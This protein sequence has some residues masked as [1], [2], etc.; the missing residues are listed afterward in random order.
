MKNIIF[1]LV[2]VFLVTSISTASDVAILTPE[3]TNIDVTK[4]EFATLIKAAKTGDIPTLNKALNADVNVNETTNTGATALMIA[5]KWGN[6][7]VIKVLLKEGADV[8]V[9]NKSG[10]TAWKFA[11]AY[12]H[13]KVAK[14][15]YSKM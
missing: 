11:K 7:E 5:A 1:S 13:E 12:G 15:L 3:S 4:K 8:N 2:L 14:F 9:K 10:H 6:L